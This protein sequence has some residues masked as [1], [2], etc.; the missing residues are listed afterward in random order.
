MTASEKITAIKAAI[1]DHEWDDNC[2]FTAE[3]AVDAIREIV[4]EEK[5]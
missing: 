1:D 4:T 5:P 3:Q 2:C